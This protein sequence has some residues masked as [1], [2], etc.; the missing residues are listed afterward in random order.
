MFLNPNDPKSE[1]SWKISKNGCGRLLDYICQNLP[2]YPIQQ[3]LQRD[4]SV[5]LN[6]NYLI[7]PILETIR[8]NIRN[9]ILSKTGYQN[10]WI[11][12]HPKPIVHPSAICYSCKRR[13]SQYGVL[14]IMSESPHKHRDPCEKCNCSS[15]QHMR[16]DYRL[17]HEYHCNQISD[18][19]SQIL[20][21]EDK[22]LY[23]TMHLANFFANANPTAIHDPFM[24][25]LN[26]MIDEEKTMCTNESSSAMNSLLYRRLVS[27]KSD[28]ERNLYRIEQD[29]IDIHDLIE[30]VKQIPS[31][32]KQID[33][34]MKDARNYYTDN[35]IS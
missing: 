4:E 26:R 33:V 35:F 28:Y 18:R 34:A 31:V 30:K 15:K 22:L 10:C 14:Y 16:I 32:K 13:Y 19:P 12:L 23:F 29:D 6:T 20:I 21:P 7:R 5:T 3:E 2:S 25:Y 1:E 24:V 17:E 27:F 8:N 9:S 11:E